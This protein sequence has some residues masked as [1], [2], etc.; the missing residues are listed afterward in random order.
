MKLSTYQTKLNRENPY[1]F[2]D[3]KAVILNC[4][5]KK[6]PALSNTEGLINMS[7]AILEANGVNT[8]VVRVVDHRIAFG[9]QPDMTGDGWDVDDWPAIQKKVLDADI[10]IIGTPIWLGEIASVTKMVIERLDA[11]SGETNGQGQS[12]YYNKTGGCLV[13]GNEDGIK[14]CSMY[15]LFALQHIGCVI[16]PQAAA[17]WVGEAGP[18]ASYLDEDSGGPENDFTN[19]STTF[20]TWNLMH[21]ARMLKEAGGVPAHG[22]QQ[23][24]WEEEASEDHPVPEMK[25]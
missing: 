19:R 11:S 8:E 3:L 22:N 16:P 15:V 4:T 2:S 24:E 5:L 14:H 20:M 10:L 18:G 7:K 13:T 9:M 25:N 17:G 6:S 1:D 23:D 12:I 21:L